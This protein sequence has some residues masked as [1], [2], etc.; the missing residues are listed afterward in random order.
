[1]NVSVAI[2][3]NNNSFSRSVATGAKTFIESLGSTKARI[4]AHVDLDT[5][6]KALGDSDK[7][8]IN[9]A[10]ATMPDVVVIAGH[11]GD[12]EPIITLIGQ[13]THRPQSVI[14][15][16]ALGT[17]ARGNFGDNARFQEC[18]IMPTQWA[19]S[20][21]KDPV[22]GWNSATFMT[23]MTKKGA[24]VSYHSASAGGAAAALLNGLD[25]LL[26]DK[27]HMCDKAAVAAYTK[28]INTQSFYG[29]L[30][31][32]GT[33]GAINKP[34]FMEQSTTGNFVKGASDVMV[35]MKDAKCWGEWTAN[36]CAFRIGGMLRADPTDKFTKY[37]MAAHY[38]FKM[39]R[40]WAKGKAKLYNIVDH[41]MP[42]N[43]DTFA[44][45]IAEITNDTK[46]SLVH[47]VVCPYTSGASE[48][49]VKS[50]SD[51]YKGLVIVWGG[52]RS[53]ITDDCATKGIHC[54][55]T[56]TKAANYTHHGLEAVVSKAMAAKN[57]SA[58]KVAII[59]N[60]NGFSADVA[61]GAKD[62]LMTD[63]MKTKVS[64]VADVTLEVYQAA[65]TDNDKKGIIEAMEKKPDVVVVVGH[66]GDV[67]GAIIAVGMAKHRPHAVIATNS[68]GTAA[69]TNFGDNA[70]YQKCVI[71]PTQWDSSS[72]RWGS[73]TDHVDPVVGWSST[74]FKTEMSKG[75]QV[76]TYHSASAGGAAVALINGLEK[77][78]I[79]NTARVGCPANTLSE[80]AGFVKGLDIDSF[81]GNLKFNMKGAIMK[82][83]YTAQ[84]QP[85]NF[86]TEANVQ[87]GLAEKS[88]WGPIKD[89]TAVPPTSGP[90]PAP[91]TSPAPSSPTPASPT[92]PPTT[93]TGSSN[94][95]SNSTTPVVVT[96]KTTVQVVM[97]I[98][99]PK[100]Q[101][102]AS[103]VADYKASIAN[104][105]GSVGVDTTSN[106]TAKVV[107]RTTVGFPVA[108][109]KSTC[110]TVMAKTA[111]VDESKVTVSPVATSTG[112]RRL[113][114]HMAKDWKVDVEVAN[115]AEAA[116]AET[117]VE[118]TDRIAEEAGKA[119]VTKADG[120]A[121]GAADVT[122][123]L[124]TRQLRL[125]VK[126]DG[127]DAAAAK[128][129]ITSTVNKVAGAKGATAA[130]DE[131]TIVTQ[132]QTTGST[133]PQKGVDPI[134]GS[135]GLFASLAAL[136]MTLVAAA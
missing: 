10:M 82:P 108:I 49:C 21:D 114:S 60:K 79:A 22:L 104:Q 67:E 63:S 45:H 123:S 93:A 52:A 9:G 71:M 110:R 98:G 118:K 99:L 130:M 58:V 131:S 18:V 100:N 24:T 113:A 8:K 112:G 133:T 16:N 46:A 25:K 105:S 56:F 34:M 94:A 91:P 70:M 37:D 136:L 135:N 50:V 86:V 77:L 115:E 61:Q 87:L 102:V 101:S 76:V 75:K 80:V 122:A 14:A 54:I 36:S 51:G 78:M 126:A 2:L 85:D 41:I 119:G 27:P 109:N 39:V 96:P 26:G 38:A 55:Q 15:T 57:G 20:E 127:A 128:A 28:G 65:L 33:T 64:M 62:L 97:D 125:P 120:S 83:M 106:V 116:A 90:T 134:S 13:N 23:E 3:C 53:T 89:D 111:G 84:H 129:A 42:H 117:A 74:A 95:S 12:V 4:V 92:P 7:S 35:G 68:L 66:P 1:V 47:A 132:T 69:T 103:A 30:Q 121:I 17:K 124:P 32:N 19:Q 6:A 73:G 59:V 43:A 5:Y 72:K 48:T 107:V 44:A 29:T 81:Y 31:F 88:C 11:N 40:D